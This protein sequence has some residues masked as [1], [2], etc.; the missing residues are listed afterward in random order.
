MTI[1]F[2]VCLFCLLGAKDGTVLTID[3]E[4]Y[5]LQQFY[6]HF[7]KKQ[8]ESVDSTKR[9]NVFADF[10]KR[11][12]CVLEAKKLGLEN[13]PD[14]AI[15]I[16][17][18]SHRLL[19]NESYEQLVAWPLINPDDIEDSRIFAQNEL[20]ISHILI[21]FAGASL[22][23]QP[24]RSIDDAFILAQNIKNRFLSGE[25]FSGL[26]EKYSDGCCSCEVNPEYL[27][28]SPKGSIF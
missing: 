26:A 12:L 14:M 15:K 18:L 4:E 27:T 1:W 11:Q 25:D 28:S 2:F 24:K 9:D 19:V 6:T 23:Q 10:I 7:S 21:G 16:R 17:D 22:A 20:L 3:S 8:W 13:N 5:S